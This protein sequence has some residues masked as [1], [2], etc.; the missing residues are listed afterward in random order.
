[1]EKRRWSEEER[2]FLLELIGTYPFKKIP[3]IFQNWAKKQGYPDRTIKAIESQ[4]DQLIAENGLSKRCFHDN[5]TMA[6]LVRSLGVSPRRILRFVN[7]GQLKT[8]RTEQEK[9]ARHQG[10][11]KRKDIAKIILDNPGY[12]S[13]CEEHRLLWILESQRLVSIVKNAPPSAKGF[14]RSVIAHRS[15]G[16]TE[17]FPS[18]AEAA[19]RSHVVSQSIARAIQKGGTSAGARWEYHG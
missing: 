12:F 15:N 14:P 13:H 5:F 19:R 6:E 1:M 11:I 2:C 8:G 16:T 10:A 9:L 17:I 18:I 7:E 3:Q 4:S